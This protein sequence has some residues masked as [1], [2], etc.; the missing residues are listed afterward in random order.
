MANFCPHCGAQLAR[1]EAPFCSTCGRSLQPRATP[2]GVAGA[3][4]RL[5][6][7]LPGHAEETFVISRP[8][9][10]IGRDPGND[11]ALDN[12]IVSRR[13]AVLEVRADA[14]WLRDIQSANGTA[15]NGRPITEQALRD[16][17]IIRIGDEQGNNVGLVFRH[18]GAGP[19]SGTIQLGRKEL[20]QA[21]VFI[22]GR[23][24]SANLQLDHPTIS[25]L[26]AEVRLTPA[27]PVLRDLGS[28]NGTFLNGAL[29][30][31]ARPLASRDVVQIGPFKLVYDQAG[32]TQYTPDGNYR[33]DA[34]HLE[35]RVLIG[36]GLSRL[37][38]GAAT[39]RLILR[40]FVEGDWP[41][42]LAYQR[43]PRYLRYYEWTDRVE[44]DV[45]P[46]VRMFVDQQRE[47]PRIRFQLAVVRRDNGRLIGNCGVR[48]DGLD[49]P[50]AEIGYELAPDE[51]GQG[52]ATEA[53]R[54]IIRFG[55]EAL[56][57][58]RF[59]AWT[60]ADNTASIR[61]LEKCGFA[62]E[63]LARRYLCINGVWQDHLLFG[64]LHEDFRG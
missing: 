53:A 64:L 39:E 8:T 1:P 14:V 3:P 56:G 2:S 12:P 48:R 22:I 6:V 50:E 4:P 21:A 18:P 7:Q 58:R 33:I 19:S 38:G 57:L 11:L 63:G 29:I 37:V 9:V 46:F 43:D 13:H 35:R 45:K 17:D 30:T 61:V 5:V 60:V 31:G 47:D 49:S 41:A 62:R 42:V 25:R 10:T 32:F 28:S 40:D 23:D 24:P 54:E 26:H 34:L 20:G 16:G 52:F 36:G 44:E 55:R 27:G 51:W 15:V 59:T